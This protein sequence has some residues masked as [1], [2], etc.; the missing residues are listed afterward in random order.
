MCTLRYH[1]WAMLV[2]HYG[3]RSL[4]HQ[5]FKHYCLEL[6]FLSGSCK[7]LGLCSYQHNVQWIRA[8]AFA[9]RHLPSHNAATT[10]VLRHLV[11]FL[12]TCNQR[13]DIKPRSVLSLQ[14]SFYDSWVYH[15]QLKFPWFSSVT[16]SNDLWLVIISCSVKRQY[17]LN[18]CFYI[19]I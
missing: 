9:A 10:T 16:H 17:Y 5:S 11:L 13:P 1:L 7:F 19:W 6:T 15:V 18:R 2:S 8:S 12:L 3:R 4:S 14:L